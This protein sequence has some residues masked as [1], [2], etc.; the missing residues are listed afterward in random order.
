[1]KRQ[2]AI[3]DI[4]GCNRSFLALLDQIAFGQ[5]DELFLLGDYVDRGPDSKGVIDTIWRLQREGY[6]VHCLA[7]N[8]EAIAL[9]DWRNETQRGWQGAGDE[10]FLAS[11]GARKCA[12]V[13]T[14]YYRWMENLD[15]H[16]EIPGY[17]LVH[18][19]LNFGSLQHIFDHPEILLWIR[20]WYTNIN[21]E[22]LG[23]RVIVHGHTPQSHAET[24]AQLAQLDSKRVID[25]D[26][27]CIT[28][29]PNGHLCAFDLTNRR[30]HFQ[31]CLER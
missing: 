18:A 28:I 24:M 27:G 15:T 22:W 8:H 7:G 1:M 2:I 31:P 4:H 17:I 11:F 3:S 29:W 21:Y 10:T 9:S 13:P 5:S 25:I 23:E 30:L 19:G 14:E 20:N 16:L 12:E 26:T 6:S